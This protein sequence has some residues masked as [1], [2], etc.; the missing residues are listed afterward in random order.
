MRSKMFIWLGFMAYQI[1]YHK[2]EQR[3]TDYSD[4]NNRKINKTTI[5][6]K[7]MAYQI[8]YHKKEQRKTDYSD[9][10]NR[11]INKTTI[12]RKQKWE[13]KRLFGWVLWHIKFCR[14]FNVKSILYK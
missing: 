2:K 4:P 12:N 9:P 1:L 13:V 7:K 10:N 8:L 5:N 11:K 3:K 6:R 14:L